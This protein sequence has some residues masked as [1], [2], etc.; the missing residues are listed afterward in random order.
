MNLVLFR[1][2]INDAVTALSSTWS[3][4]KINTKLSSKVEGDGI[5][6]IE[7]ITQA[8]YTAL[9]PKISTTLYIIVN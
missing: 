8:A 3:S 7:K 5:L 4:T 2:G 9:T 6:K 1:T